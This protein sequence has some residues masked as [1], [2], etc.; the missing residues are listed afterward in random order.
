[1]LTWPYILAIAAASLGLL[2]MAFVRWARTVPGGEPGIGFIWLADRV[3]CRFMHRAAVSGREHVPTTNAPGG[4]VVVSNHT[5]PIDALAIQA[6]CRFQ[7]RWIMA[8]DMMVPALQWLWKRNPV[9][10]VSRNGRDSGPVR[11]AIRHVKAGGV[12]GVFPEGA[13]VQPRHELRPFHEGV[14]L[15]ISRTRAPVLLVWVTGTPDSPRMGEALSTRSRTRVV[16]LDLIEFEKGTRPATIARSLRER[17]A[18]ASGWPVND[19]PL[20]PPAPP[21]RNGDPFAVA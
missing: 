18:E 21:V 6:A 10:A 12:V 15:I 17:L 19:E 7:I 5:G 11:E 3:Y 20:M 8:V 9:I 4:L 2:W 1:M 13:I 14:G 16:F